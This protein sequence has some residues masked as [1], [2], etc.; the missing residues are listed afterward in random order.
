MNMREVSGGAPPPDF[1]GRVVGRGQGHAILKLPGGKEISCTGELE[2]EP[3]KIARLVQGLNHRVLVSYNNA[4]S[5]ERLWTFV[6]KKKLEEAAPSDYQGH[7]FPTEQIIQGI[8]YGSKGDRESYV[9][10]HQEAVNRLPLSDKDK[11][12]LLEHIK[13]SYGQSDIRIWVYL[14]PE[15]SKDVFKCLKE[16]EGAGTIS[17]Q[18]VMVFHQ[19][20]SLERKKGPASQGV[21]LDLSP[22]EK[23]ISLAG[24]HNVEIRD[25][26]KK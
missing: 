20:V 8:K 5:G 1:T 13:N 10:H 17:P 6:S 16:T 15:N 2:R 12:R 24:P 14:H 7:A 11:E 18:G 22:I 26:V 3:G 21:E 19:I 23:A 9:A 4:G 25:A